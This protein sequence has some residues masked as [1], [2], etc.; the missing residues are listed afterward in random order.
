MLL[1]LILKSGV[2]PEFLTDPQLSKRFRIFHGT[3][4][5]ITSKTVRQFLYGPL[6]YWL[7]YWT[8]FFSPSTQIQG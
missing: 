4:R 1:Q 5:I 3:L 8:G 2:F 7:R 6:S